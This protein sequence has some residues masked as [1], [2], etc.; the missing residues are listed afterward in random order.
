MAITR[1]QPTPRQLAVIPVSLSFST[2]SSETSG[3][4]TNSTRFG[5]VS[6]TLG[7]DV[8]GLSPRYG[9]SRRIRRISSVTI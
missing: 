1:G 4:E 3:S 2:G 5:L 6:V 7:G 8:R 9:I